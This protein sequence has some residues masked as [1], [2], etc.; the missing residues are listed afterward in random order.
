VVHLACDVLLLGSALYDRT[1]LDDVA[2][3]AA[4][5]VGLVANFIAVAGL[6]TIVLRMPLAIQSSRVQKEEIVRII[7][8]Q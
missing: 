8:A 4:V 5:L 2:P 1:V 3:P 6:L 7:P